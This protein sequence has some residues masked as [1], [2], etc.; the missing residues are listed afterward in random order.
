MFKIGE[1]VVYGHSGVCQVT[2]IDY[3]ELAFHVGDKKLYY[4]LEPVCS[5]EVIYTPVDTKVQMR[6]VISSEQA[7]QL[8]DRVREEIKAP[9]D[10]RSNMQDEYDALLKNQKCT[11]L[12]RIIKN[13]QYK[14]KDSLQSGKKLT[15]TEQ[16]IL[17]QAEELLSSELSV[18]MDKDLEATKSIIDDVVTEWLARVYV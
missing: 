10:V 4:K 17:K 13:I 2:S 9:A 12:L 8:L 6:P 7:R 3:P 15:M 16:R 18:V 5:T 14:K 11:G 1:F